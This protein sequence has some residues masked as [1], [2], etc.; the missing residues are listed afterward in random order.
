MEQLVNEDTW[1]RTINGVEISSRIDHVYTTVRS[2]IVNLKL[3]NNAYS[4]HEMVKFELEHR[5]A[6]QSF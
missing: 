3:V 4:D 2:R 6:N 5:N 1:S